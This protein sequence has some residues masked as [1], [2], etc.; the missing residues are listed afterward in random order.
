MSKTYAVTTLAVVFVLCGVMVFAAEEVPLADGH[1]WEASSKVEKVAYIVGVS[2][3]MSIEYAYQHRNEDPP[4]YDQTM[5]QAL[6][7]GGEDVSVETAISAIDKWYEDHP[8]EKDKAV[9]N[10]VWVLWVEPMLAEK[11]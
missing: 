4:N 5:I 7:D 2:N 10:V 3:L 1:G 11:E 8:G 6:W 9:L